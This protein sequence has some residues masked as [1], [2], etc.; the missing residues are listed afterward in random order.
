V[1]VRLGWEDDDDEIHKCV[2]CKYQCCDECST[3]QGVFFSQ[4]NSCSSSSSP[5][6][7]EC[8]PGIPTK[9]YEPFFFKEK[10]QTNEC[11]CHPTIQHVRA[12]TMKNDETRNLFICN[13]CLTVEDPFINEDEFIQFIIS[14]YTT[15]ASVEE[16][17]KRARKEYIPEIVLQ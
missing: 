10:I 9:R 3:T 2:S 5:E 13:S 7:D 12:E 14:K 17:Y 4:H 16:A 6:V 8:I 11:V 15:F 1:L